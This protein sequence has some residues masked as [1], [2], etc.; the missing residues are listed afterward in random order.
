[1]LVNEGKVVYWKETGEVPGVVWRRG[2][3]DILMVV[4]W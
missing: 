2:W 3:L 4:L 1:M